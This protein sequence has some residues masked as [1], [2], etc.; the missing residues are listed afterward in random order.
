V[1]DVPVGEKPAAVPF[2][3]RATDAVAS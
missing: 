1:F 3:R 2:G